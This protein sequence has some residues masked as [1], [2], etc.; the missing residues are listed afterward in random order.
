MN[1]I[2]PCIECRIRHVCSDECGPYVNYFRRLIKSYARYGN[3]SK[4]IKAAGKQFPFKK[5]YK[6][7]KGIDNFY[8]I[9][10]TRTRSGNWYIINRRGR[11]LEYGSATDK[12]MIDRMFE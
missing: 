7:K 11:L 8:N 5:L 10:L 4:L 1:A 2:F 3:R 9:K 12:P 6:L